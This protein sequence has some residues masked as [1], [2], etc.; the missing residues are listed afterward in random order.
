MDKISDRL[1][2]NEILARAWDTLDR[3][4]R[5]H[6]D[7]QQVAVARFIIEQSLSYG[8]G[9]APWLPVKYQTELEWAELNAMKAKVATYVG[10]VDQEETVPADLKNEVE[11]WLRG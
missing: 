2:L 1:E 5:E 7:G 3:A 8:N 6:V 11:A 4:M 9:Q 10:L